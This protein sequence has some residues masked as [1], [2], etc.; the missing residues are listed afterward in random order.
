MR[1][2]TVNGRSRVFGSNVTVGGGTNIDEGVYIDGS[3]GEVTIGRNCGIFQGVY[4][5]PR[6]KEGF[7]RI[8]D[9]TWIE[10]Y[11]VIFGQ[12]GVT[13]GK[14]VALAPMTQIAAYNHPHGGKPETKKGIKIGDHVTT[15]M[16]A[17]ILDGV[18]IGDWAT[19]GAGAVVTRSVPANAT[20]VGNPARVIV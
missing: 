8:G 19:I 16:N 1:F 20:V 15:G 14:D 13:I 11:T 12:G 5:D 17:T 2:A 4:I 3:F 18:E 10:P 9:G 6:I 7:V